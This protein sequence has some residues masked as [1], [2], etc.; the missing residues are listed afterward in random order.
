MILEKSASGAA[1]SAAGIATSA[2]AAKR[3]LSMKDKVMGKDLTEE[4]RANGKP[5]A[6]GGE[7]AVAA[8]AGAREGAYYLILYVSYL[9]N[10]KG[11]GRQHI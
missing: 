10:S 6:R 2:C 4:R 3:T 5:A 7:G 8:G 1:S 9:G 11:I